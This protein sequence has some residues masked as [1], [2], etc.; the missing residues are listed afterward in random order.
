MQKYKNCIIFYKNNKKYMAYFNMSEYC[1]YRAYLRI[2]Y[3]K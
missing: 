3:E 2:I 1:I